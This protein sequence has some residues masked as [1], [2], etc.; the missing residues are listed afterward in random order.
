[1]KG[2]VELLGM[3]QLAMLCIGVHLISIKLVVVLSTQTSMPFL[4]THIMPYKNPF[5]IHVLY[6]SQL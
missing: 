3:A 5:L 4:E 2:K 1:M 6:D